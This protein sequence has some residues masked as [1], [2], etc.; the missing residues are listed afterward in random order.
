LKTGTFYR[1]GPGLSGVDQDLFRYREGEVDVLT[2]GMGEYL[3][4]VKEVI[5]GKQLEFEDVK[6]RIKKELLERKRRGHLS[7]TVNDLIERAKIT[8]SKDG[9]KEIKGVP[10]GPFQET[11]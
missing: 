8:F 6:E 10:A 9:E 2:S 4:R 7:S 5:E 3:I 11:G 1:G